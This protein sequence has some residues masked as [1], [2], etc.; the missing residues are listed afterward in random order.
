MRSIGWRLN[1]FVIPAHLSSKRK[2]SEEFCWFMVVFS[3][4]DGPS[5]SGKAA[6]KIWR[7]CC[8][9]STVSIN[10][11]QLRDRWGLPCFL[12]VF[13][14]LRHFCRGQNLYAS[15]HNWQSWSG[16]TYSYHHWRF[17]HRLL[18]K[19]HNLYFSDALNRLYRNK[20]KVQTNPIQLLLVFTVDL[21]Q[22]VH[23][24]V[25]KFFFANDIKWFEESTYRTTNTWYFCSLDS[26]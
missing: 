1:V 7:A 26:T 19:V 16:S 4:V 3:S 8:R 10:S 18:N 15:R 24:L 21:C 11:R 22:R 20:T 12:T 14:F 25:L 13:Q 9:V 5:W 17:E 2:R 6:S 23:I